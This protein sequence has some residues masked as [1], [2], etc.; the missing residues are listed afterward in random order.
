MILGRESLEPIFNTLVGHDDR[1][2]L[3]SASIDIRIGGSCLI[4]P[5]IQK[6]EEREDGYSELTPIEWAPI[7]ID[8]CNSYLLNPGELVLVSTLETI[9]APLDCAID[10]RLKSSIARAGFDHALAF[11][12]DPGWSG[13]LTMEVKN[14]TSDH[15]LE[16]VYG[17]RF[18][19]IIVHR[20]E[21]PTQFGYTGKYN[22]AETVEGPK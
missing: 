13:V 17:M 20:L 7:T 2:Y 21:K 10:L 8:E 1:Q 18:A 5:P 3:N 22:F 16:L 14:N 19:Q 15:Y 4:E 6:A 12:V 11:W 9:T